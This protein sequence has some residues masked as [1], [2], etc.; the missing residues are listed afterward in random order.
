MPLLIKKEGAVY[1]Y[2]DDDDDFEIDDDGS[3]KINL[4]IFFEILRYSRIRG[5][6][7][8]NK[9]DISSGS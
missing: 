4:D 1:Y 7:S 5:K 2:Y 9:L 6:S 3:Q 8:Q